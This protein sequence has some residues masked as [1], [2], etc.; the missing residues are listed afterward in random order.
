MAAALGR[1]LRIAVPDG[2]FGDLEAFAGH[3]ES[4]GGLEFEVRR[5]YGAQKHLYLPEDVGEEFH[6]ARQLLVA[7]DEGL[8]QGE[9]HL[10]LLHRLGSLGAGLVDLSVEGL[11]RLE[12][13]R[14]CGVDRYR[15]KHVNQ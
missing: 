2:A 12:H 9:V 10:G 14:E 13:L 5:G 8:D 4:G 1:I 7:G 6:A 15:R 3:V 11:E